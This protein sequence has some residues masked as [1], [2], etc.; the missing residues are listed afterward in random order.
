MINRDDAVFVFMKKND[1]MK[2][3][4]IIIEKG[5]TTAAFNVII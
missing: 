3:F 2:T 5:K 1:I 4:I